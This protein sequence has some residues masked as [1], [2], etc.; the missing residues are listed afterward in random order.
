MA[1]EESKM[2]EL[3]ELFEQIPHSPQRHPL[4]V[5][6]TALQIDIDYISIR[7]GK[8]AF[9]CNR[10]VRHDGEDPNHC[11]CLFRAESKKLKEYKVHTSRCRSEIFDP[12]TDPRR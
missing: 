5:I 4:H 1:G 9:L 6:L 2:I 8:Y 3:F 10:S 7:R 12:H 11:F